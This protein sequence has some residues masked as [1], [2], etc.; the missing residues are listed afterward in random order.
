MPSPSLTYTLTNSTTADASA[1][2]QNF[3]DLLNAMTDGSKDFSISA[4]T[5]AGAATLNGHV[6]LGNSSADDLTITA[7]LAS[8]LPIKTDGTY[9][10]GS[11]ALGLRYVYLGDGGGDTARIGVASLSADRQYTVPEVSANADF[12][13][14]QG[15]QTITGVKTFSSGIAFANETLS[16]Y[17][18]GSWQ[19]SIGNATWGGGTAPTWYF[20]KVG[21]NVTVSWN[22]NKGF[23]TTAASYVEFGN[24]PAALLPG[25]TET[26]A[27]IGINYNSAGAAVASIYATT[28]NFRL[29]RSVAQD[30]FSSGGTSVITQGS[31]SYRLID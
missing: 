14:T 7:S 25:S 1:V 17:D 11:A 23:T 27:M 30:T 29:Y 10:I 8:S 13:M 15:A 4:L 2:M 9:D 19:P 24:I 6:N 16:T 21:K 22:G 5:C 20:V 31:F 18:E 26:G 3:N 12:V 28:T